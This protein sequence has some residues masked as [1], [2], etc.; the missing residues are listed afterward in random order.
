MASQRLLPTYPDSGL[1]SR[2]DNI[3]ICKAKYPYQDSMIYPHIYFKGIS[4]GSTD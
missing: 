1:L 4:G 3:F 2:F